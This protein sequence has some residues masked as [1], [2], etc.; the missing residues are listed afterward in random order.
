VDSSNG[1]ISVGTALADVHAESANGGIRI[2]E[3][4]CGRVD[5]RAAA[6]ELE[7][8]VRE[9]TAAWLDVSTRVGDVRNSRVPA[10]GRTPARRPSRCAPS[11]ASATS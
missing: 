9:S 11:P 7:V 10:E 1:R 8:G 2:G 5:L 6:G 3:V 4:A